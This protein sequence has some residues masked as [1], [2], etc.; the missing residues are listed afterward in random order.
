MLPKLSVVI[1]CYKAGRDVRKYVEEAVDCLDKEIDSWQIVLV[2]NYLQGETDI[3]PQV[4]QEIAE[5]NDRI[6]AVTKVKEGMMGWDVRSGFVEATG[7]VVAL[8]D[9]DGQM[10]FRDVIH[11]YRVLEKENC[12]IVTTYRVERYDGCYR[13]LV[14]RVYNLIFRIFFGGLQVRDINSKPKLI[15]RSAYNRLDLKSNDWFID[16]EIMIQARRLRLKIREISV[17]FYD[18]KTRRSFVRVPAILEFIKNLLLARIKE[19]IAR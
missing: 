9:G 15:T 12:D 3:T 5:A 2:G 19:F 16:A 7:G 8:I 17:V 6:V 11:A 10:A 14:S 13:F 18:L 1:L 4:V